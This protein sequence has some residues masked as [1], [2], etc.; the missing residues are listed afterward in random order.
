MKERDQEQV[1]VKKE[2]PVMQGEQPK[3]QEQPVLQQEQ[4]KNETLLAGQQ[5]L[6][7]VPKKEEKLRQKDDKEKTEEKKIKKTATLKKVE[8]NMPEPIGE[9]HQQNNAPL[10]DHHIRLANSAEI[11]RTGE[12]QDTNNCYACSGSIAFNQ[13]LQNNGELTDLNKANQFKIRRYRPEFRTFDEMKGIIAAKLGIDLSKKEGADEARRLYN[14]YCAEIT[15]YCGRGKTEVGNIYE[16][17]DYFLE[18][19]K[20]VALH[21]MTFAVPSKEFKTFKTV[22]GVKIP[23]PYDKD[24]K[25]AADQTYNDMKTS[26]LNKL[27]EVLDSGNAVSFLR[28]HHYVTIVGIDGQKLIYANSTSPGVECSADVETFLDRSGY[29][30]S[31]EMT[32]FSKVGDVQKLK[33]DYPN[34]EYDQ[35]NGFTAQDRQAGDLLYVSQKK[36]ISVSRDVL[37][38]LVTESVYLPTNKKAW[39][40]EQLEEDKEVLAGVDLKTKVHSGPKLEELKEAVSKEKKDPLQESGYTPEFWEKHWESLKLSSVESLK[41]KITEAKRQYR[42]KE[43]KK[44]LVRKSE[45]LSLL[46]DDDAFWEQEKASLNGNDK[47]LADHERTGKRIELKG[48]LVEQILIDDAVMAVPAVSEIMTKYQALDTLLSDG[49]TTLGRVEEL[50][51]HYLE[52]IGDLNR[53]L[54]SNLAERFISKKKI[55][56]LPGRELLQQLM[57]LVQT[58]RDAL[59]GDLA[60]W[61]ENGFIPADISTGRDIIARKHIPA[62]L[63]DSP[64]HIM[65]KERLALWSRRRDSGKDDSTQMKAVKDAFT[66]LQLALNEKIYDAPEDMQE[67]AK[68]LSLIFD[69]LIKKSNKYLKDHKNPSSDDGKERRDAVEVI[70]NNAKTQ[71]VGIF[72]AA[73]KM[74]EW[75]LTGKTWADAYGLSVNTAANLFNKSMA[76]RENIE[77]NRQAAIK[78]DMI[79]ELTKVKQSEVS[80]RKKKEVLITDEKKRKAYIRKQN[81]KKATPAMVLFFRTGIWKPEATKEDVT[82]TK[83]ARQDWVIGKFEDWAY[84]EF[85]GNEWISPEAYRANVEE[86]N[87]HAFENLKKIHDMDVKKLRDTFLHQLMSVYGN[88]VSEDRV[89]EFGALGIG[90]ERMVE[91]QERLQRGDYDKKEYGSMKEYYSIERIVN[92]RFDLVDDEIRNIYKNKLMKSPICMTDSAM[93][94]LFVL[95]E[96]VEDDE[97]YARLEKLREIGE[98]NDKVTKEL[99]LQMRGRDIYDSEVIRKLILGEIK[100]NDKEFELIRENVQ[101]LD[102]LIS[103]MVRDKFSELS[104]YEVRNGLLEFLGDKVL[105]GKY[106]LVRDL[107]EEYIEKISITNREAAR[108]END[109]NVAYEKAMKKGVFSKHFK[110]AGAYFLSNSRRF[111]RHQKNKD[112][113]AGRSK[114][115]RERLRMVAL[116]DSV[117]DEETK[118]KKFTRNTWN[119]LMGRSE[120]L[121]SRKLSDVDTPD[122]GW[123]T[124]SDEENKLREQIRTWIRADI[125]AKTKYEE[126]KPGVKVYID[127]KEFLDEKEPVNDYVRKGK[128]KHINVIR[129]D[130][131]TFAGLL[132]GSYFI[133]SP[134]IV[135]LIPDAELRKFLCDNIGSA[136]CCNPELKELFPFLKNIES[137]DQLETLSISQYKTI[138]NYF[139]NNLLADD[140]VNGVRNLLT[141]SEKKNETKEQREI[142]KYTLLE[143]MKHKTDEGGMRKIIA[144]Q[145]KMLSSADE[146][147]FKRVMISL[148]KPARMRD[149]KIHYRYNDIMQGEKSFFKSDTYFAKRLKNFDRAHEVWGLL[150]KLGPEAVVQVRNWIVDIFNATKHS[151]KKDKD[152]PDE[153]YKKLAAMLSHDYRKENENIQK[154]IEENKKK[155]KEGKIPERVKFDFDVSPKLAEG[156]RKR[157]ENDPAFEGKDLL[158]AIRDVFMEGRSKDNEDQKSPLPPVGD[159]LLEMS[160]FDYHDL[161]L[162][163]GG[164]A[165]GM[166]WV[167]KTTKSNTPYRVEMYKQSIDTVQK[168]NVLERELERFKDKQFREILRDKLAPLY[169]HMEFDHTRNRYKLNRSYEKLQ[170]KTDKAL[171]LNEQYLKMKAM[172]EQM[173]GAAEN[174]QEVDQNA[175]EELRRNLEERK[176]EADQAAVDLTEFQKKQAELLNTR[177]IAKMGDLELEEIQENERKFGIGNIGQ[178]AGMLLSNISDDG[179][180]STQLCD[181][182]ALYDSRRKLFDNYGGGE[183]APFWDELEKIDEIF[184]DFID[185]ADTVAE[186]RIKKIYEK[187]APL[188][189]A[190]KEQYSYVN[191]YFIENEIRR[192]ME[193]KE[194]AAQEVWKELEGKSEKDQIKYWNSRLLAAQKQIVEQGVKGE[195]SVHKNMAACHAG[196]RKQLAQY[197][198]DQPDFEKKIKEQESIIEG[199]LFADSQILKL[200]EKNKQKF[201][202]SSALA[203][204]KADGVI[205]N[206]ETYILTD[207]E[208]MEKAYNKGTLEEYYKELATHYFKNSELAERT[209]VKYILRTEYEVADADKMDDV[210]LNEK[211]NSLTKEQK[212]KIR[213]TKEAFLAHVEGPC[214]KEKAI[215][216]EKQIEER[217]KYFVTETNAQ[218][219]ADISFTEEYREGAR[220][221]LEARKKAAFEVTK[222]KSEGKKAYSK[223]LFGDKLDELKAFGEKKKAIIYTRPGQDGS[224][225]MSRGEKEDKELF[226]EA[227][228]HFM[229][230]GGAPEYPDILADCL[231]EYMR[232]NSGILDKADRVIDW[233]AREKNDIDKEEKRLKAIYNYG[234]TKAALPDYAVDFYVAYMAKNVKV[235][236]DTDEGLELAI[237]E[238]S[239]EIMPYIEKLHEMDVL[240]FR[241]PSLKLAHRDACEKMRAYLFMQNDRSAKDLSDFSGM[242]DAQKA[243]FTHAETA[244]S[245]IEEAVRS[246]SYT[247][248]LEKPDQI[249]YIN[250]LYEYFVA[251]MLAESKAQMDDHSRVFDAGAFKTKVAKRIADSASREALMVKDGQVSYLDMREKNI[252]A[253]GADQNEF[254]QYMIRSFGDEFIKDYNALDDEQKKLFA[255]GLYVGKTEERGTMRAIYGLSNTEV[256]AARKDIMSYMRSENVTLQVD[257]GKAMRALTASG[258]GAKVLADKSLFDQALVFVKQVES[259]RDE[260]RPKDYMR[261]AD[262]KTIA[263][264]ADSFRAHLGTKHKDFKNENYREVLNVDLDDRHAFLNKL[265]EYQKSDQTR[266]EDKSKRIQGIMEQVKALTVSQQSLLIYVLQD[267]TVLDNSAMKDSKTKLI[268][269]VNSEKRFEIFDKLQSSEGR[270]DALKQAADP[271]L[272]CESM[273]QLL[274]FQLRDDQELSEGELK[275]S[276]FVEKSL[277]RRDTLDWDLLQRGIDF[278]NEIENERLRIST[279]RLAGELVKSEDYNK[280][281]KE[282]QFYNRHMPTLLNISELGQEEKMES[283]IHQAYAE[284]KADI[285]KYGLRNN[286]VM[287]DLMAGFTALSPEEKNLFYRALEHRDILDVSQKNLYLNIFGMGERDY[288]NPK[289]R[290]DLADEFISNKGD[291]QLGRNAYE[292]ALLSLCSTQ[293]NDDMDFTKIKGVSQA[294]RNLTVTNQLMV[295]ERGTLF[296]GKT[297][298]DWKLFARAL[299]FVYRTVNEMKLAAGDEEIYKALGDKTQGE[300]KIDRSYLRQNLHHTGVRFLRFLGGEAAQQLESPIGLFDTAT[301]YADFVLSAKTT[302]FLKRKSRQMAGKGEKNEYEKA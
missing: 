216:F 201:F 299:Q 160:M 247:G 112:Q 147:R 61:K 243:F 221:R 204:R 167:D 69:D 241:Q 163:H 275:E 115:M 175:I 288:V 237:K 60:L 166:L 277:K 81:M 218:L 253:G 257:Y 79:A 185:P 130:D 29:G 225:V 15:A 180:L 169:L 26:L 194:P 287:D 282:I 55:K 229:K 290:D 262:S 259:Q 120:F 97:D 219:E 276:D 1:Q 35:E 5:N 223:A 62:E 2:Q 108:M 68:L 217:A 36:G 149:G 200:A 281:S 73:K 294:E 127:R 177:D 174:G 119:W 189:K 205:Y 14:D 139:K 114:R 138:L 40:N 146:I 82:K 111:W 10:P 3:Q 195:R 6:Q 238:V 251:D 103:D 158:S 170:E 71:K 181:T 99:N 239:K 54:N 33:E 44:A 184:K 222:V 83:N 122:E 176:K 105:F 117:L 230:K 17:G 9:A 19:S 90:Y 131:Y 249:R 234:K 116:M 183:L 289:G 56:A 25:E 214:I 49:V 152:K 91:E 254:E 280:D 72:V 207:P 252:Y 109:Y 43:A 198:L 159:Y 132:R 186:E 52:L 233:I 244:L 236:V 128:V 283:I 39:E 291:V 53:Y 21:K 188:G 279:V 296:G 203:L 213:N 88:H 129:K 165:P 164:N 197:F 190:L 136:V 134:E 220:K 101:D 57:D 46:C 228:K 274:S 12:L 148:G 154:V 231:D 232:V 18:R 302:N 209:I 137:L 113:T 42:S 268:P 76:T 245:V 270:L 208:C 74:S 142:R 84:D 269:F 85:F 215:D 45:M 192:L 125:E 100:L 107:A 202:E 102:K 92:L 240:N 250:G 260:L 48:V 284:D 285:K 64:K 86:M 272:I 77:K 301:D 133:E 141:D 187:L 178:I 273:R 41:P 295:T 156:F 58:E 143:V 63:A 96:I 168:V 173:E 157:H 28:N 151:E 95:N 126:K 80:S 224:Q 265:M 78:N 264:A 162:S 66:K 124:T 89:Q 24:Q 293:V 140:V 210:A 172:L 110:Q 93:G 98:N 144:D 227:K 87:R 31:V 145:Q 235:N 51:A 65:Y 70:L 182:V 278:V 135:N 171:N 38:S 16:L 118:D 37:G 30:T 67:Q 193:G 191:E 212:R 27:K 242:I 255:M 94:F 266:A 258:K 196:L 206:I 267:R 34:L 47:C 32:W 11:I 256:K 286:T 13:F 246:D 298:F 155:K 297:R 4:K 23:V 106:N 248:L 292:K 161:V 123:F 50:D 150:E 121:I 8:K 300:M 199:G 20:D 263:Q 226:K 211:L 7:A 59:S 22:N 271:K 153:R 179:Q 104:Y 261:M 75:K